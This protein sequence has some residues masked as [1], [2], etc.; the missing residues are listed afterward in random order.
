VNDGQLASVP[1]VGGMINASGQIQ[2]PAAAAMTPV[3]TFCAG[4]VIERADLNT[5]ISHPFR[6]SAR[7]K[8]PSSA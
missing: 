5:A 1:D 2:A 7:P 6:I 4:G 8:R 3:I